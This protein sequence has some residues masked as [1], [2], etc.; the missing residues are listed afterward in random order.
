MASPAAGGKK[1]QK[2]EAEKTEVRKQNQVAAEPF[3]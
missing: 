3:S 1:S 2:L